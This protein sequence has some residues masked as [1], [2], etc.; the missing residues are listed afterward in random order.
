MNV[1]LNWA[2]EYSN[3]PLNDI[4][5]ESLLLKMGAQL[6]AI[7]EVVNYGARFDSVVVAKIIVCEKHPDA[8]R[9]SVCKINDGGVT[10]NIE[11][12]EAGLIQVVCGAPNAREGIVVAWLPPGATVPATISDAEPFVLSK[13][14]I[15]G[16][17]SN[18]M[19][20][21]P[22]ELG[23]S[24]EHEGILEIKVADVGHELTKPGT[25]FNKL[26]SLEDT[27][28]DCEN[29]MFTHRPDCFGI[30][31]VA[32]EIAGIQQLPFKSP[33]WY[34]A[35]PEFENVDELELE[36]SIADETLCSRLMAVAMKDVVVARS[37]L[38][39]Q[40]ALSRVGLKPINNIV[41]LT[42]YYMHLTG[43]PI[44]AYDYD[45]LKAESTHEP[46]VV[47]RA[48]SKGEKIALL[49]GKTLELESGTLIISTD[50]TPVA[51]AGIMGGSETEVDQ[52]TKNIILEVATFDMYAIRRTS[53]QYGLFT[54][55][56]T[57]F[58][59]GQSP[60]QN[61]RVLAQLMKSITDLSGGKQASSVLNKQS[62]RVEPLPHVT[63]SADFINV[64]LGSN[65]SADTI[66][67][68]LNNVEINTTLNEDNITVEI[69]FWR[70]DLEEPEDIVEEVGRL[71]GFNALPVALPKRNSKAPQ[72]DAMVSWK[73][74][75]RTALARL[76]ASELLTYSFVHSDLLAKA[77][78]NT[79][80]V[81]HVRNAISPDLQ[82]YRLTLM[83]SLLDKVR[84]NIKSDRITDGRNEFALFEINKVHIRGVQDDV[85][86]NVP[87][88]HEH[89]A[90]VFSADE[91]TAA[92]SYDG[93]AYY[94]AAEYLKSL[95]NLIGVNCK[96]IPVDPALGPDPVLAP[97]DLN[98]T[99]S[100]V[101]NDAVVGFVGEFNSAVEK[102]FKLP[103]FSAGFEVNISMLLTGKTNKKYIT[104]PTFP[105]T[106]QDI[107]FET[108]GSVPFQ[109]VADAVQAYLDG[110]N[111]TKEFYLSIKPKDIYITE[112]G[113]QRVTF[114]IWFARYDR[115]LQTAEVNQILDNLAAHTQETIQV[116]R[117]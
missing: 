81:F 98:R 14:E 6:G 101:V 94:Q 78:L 114:R 35:E 29:K 91:K 44:H 4:G 84:L 115:T 73:F 105:K 41:D 59:K 88:E 25:P 116:V 33:D 28:I 67:T 40:S 62:L 92:N 107:T 34:T 56:V 99:A 52:N 3:V 27:V 7:E 45:K 74:T 111:S 66:C 57:R 22:R 95:C 113:K 37:P 11:R 76:G 55:A 10:E 54:D 17:T 72:K 117:I 87:A 51:I 65:L 39:L 108:D 64:R 60:L 112:E 23:I 38:W 46:V 77:G 24:D 82:Y 21:S 19:L 12:D 103:A 18:G 30:L 49:N 93:A 20:A 26:Y 97:F 8:D 69:P 102:A 110:L 16:Q 63:V 31:G 42:N 104:M 5:T 68:L 15:R 96:L 79:E 80:H 1:S 85:E 106:E 50:V 90:L 61:D 83:P 70:R 71:H 58:T 89:M 109:Y 9:L 32:R 36:I 53:M 100:I 47:A 2:Q 86:P 43:Q 13:R 75:L 48:A